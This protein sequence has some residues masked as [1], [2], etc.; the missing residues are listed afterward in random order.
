MDRDTSCAPGDGSEHD[1]GLHGGPLDLR[2]ESKT[3][4]LSCL[5]DRPGDLPLWVSSVGLNLSPAEGCSRRSA[6]RWAPDFYGQDGDAALSARHP[7]GDCG[8][9]CARHSCSLRLDMDWLIPHPAMLA[10]DGKGSLWSVSWSWEPAIVVPLLVLLALYVAGMCRRGGVSR[11]RWRHASFLAGWLTLFFALTSPIHELGEQL[12]SAHMLQHEVLILISAPFL[13]A[14]HPGVTCLWALAPRHRSEAGRWMK[15]IERSPVVQSVTA[16]LNAWV[17]EAVAL[18]AWHIPFLYQAALTSDW[19]HAAQ[20]LS[21]LGT[22]VL[23]W[24]A[25]YGVGR[26]AMSFGSATLYVFGTAVHCSALGALLT[27]SSVLWY[28]AYS[29]TTVRWGLTP[30]QDQQLGGVIMWVPSGIVFLV[31]ALALVARWLAESDRRVRLG[32]LA[33][34]MEQERE[35]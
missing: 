15:A 14:A 24:S 22:A 5:R 2:Y 31:I 33:A 25:L 12:F 3:V 11:L 21:F 17:L 13:S 10:L 16:P 7:A 19:M 8:N 6:S 26:T 18:W 4:L 32:S 23:F 29:T 1:R 28:P 35:P 27:F 30:L 34:A 9:S 20:H